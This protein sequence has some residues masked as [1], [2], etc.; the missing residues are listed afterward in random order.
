MAALFRSIKG[1]SVVFLGFGK[2]IVSLP[3]GE[4]GKDMTRSSIQALFCFKLFY[5]LDFGS[6]VHL[7]RI[8]PLLKRKKVWKPLNDIGYPRGDCVVQTQWGREW[9]QRELRLSSGVCGSPYLS[10]VV[11]V[12]ADSRY[13]SRGNF[14]GLSKLSLPSPWQN[15]WCHLWEEK[16]GADVQDHRVSQKPL[17]LGRGEEEDLQRPQPR[18]GDKSHY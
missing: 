16:G 9:E 7:E 5:R 2:P 11:L 8:I 12:G 6:I 13:L 4:V 14:R 15:G 10:E 3:G 1:S 17:D 18:K